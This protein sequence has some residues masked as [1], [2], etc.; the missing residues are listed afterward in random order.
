MTEEYDSKYT[1]EDIAFLD[2]DAAQRT[3]EMEN[4]SLM[5]ERLRQSAEKGKGLMNDSSSISLSEA[6]R[7]ARS[8]QREQEVMD[9]LNKALAEAR[10]KGRKGLNEVPAETK[11]TIATGTQLKGKIEI[12]IG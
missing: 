3:E 8:K 4:A 12:R 11:D 9:E 7:L 2:A 10:L 1:Q 5:Q 6:D